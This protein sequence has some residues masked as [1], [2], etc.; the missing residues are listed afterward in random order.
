MIFL[1]HKTTRLIFQCLILGFMT[2][3]VVYIPI[4]FAQSVNESKWSKSAKSLTIFQPG[5]AVRIR[6]WELF[7]EGKTNINLNNDYSIDSEGF[8][9]MPVVGEVKVKG[10]TAY[11]LMQTLEGKFRQYFMNPYIYVRPLIRVTMQGAFNQPGAYRVDPAS[12]LWDLVALAGGPRANCDLEKMRIERGGRV[13]NKSILK[14]FEEGYSLEEIGIESGDQILAPA[15]GGID[16]R[17]LV[18]V[19]N[20]FASLALLYLRVRSGRW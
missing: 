9:V 13:I 8:I 15:Y 12:S 3:S 19:V 17:F 4:F 7:S 2:L 6:V 16:L 5:D 20:L 14:S 10:L 18:T 1:R 11:E